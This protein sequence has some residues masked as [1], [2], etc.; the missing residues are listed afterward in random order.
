MTELAQWLAP[1]ATMIA[2]M[3]T[4]ANLSARVTGWGFVVFTLGSLSWTTVGVSSGQTNLVVANSFLTVVNLVGVWRWLGRQQAY[5]EGGRSAHMASRR[6]ATPTLFTASGFVG[7][8]VEARNG[9]PIGKAVEAL[10]T[11]NNGDISYVVVATSNAVGLDEEL[12]PVAREDC[13]FHCDRLVV[14]MPR[15]EFL[16]IAPVRQGAWPAS[17]GTRADL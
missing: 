12:R 9:E 11:C 1:V 14:E 2:A 15:L 3:M 7:L 4:A 10:I 5:E 6:S 13:K 17:A 8:P 16:K